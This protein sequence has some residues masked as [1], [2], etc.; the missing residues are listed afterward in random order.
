MKK[1]FQKTSTPTS[2]KGA[3][4][5]EGSLSSDLDQLKPNITK[6]QKRKRFNSLLCSDEEAAEFVHTQEAELKIKP[7]GVANKDLL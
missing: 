3:S 4:S 2:L 6:R 1:T 7:A 5:R